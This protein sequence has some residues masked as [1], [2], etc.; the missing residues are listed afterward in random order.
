VAARLVAD[1][2]IEALSMR[3][4]AAECGVSSMTPY[5]YVGSKEEV[6][7]ALANRYLDE[8]DYPD[9]ESLSWED[10]LRQV[11]RSVRSV[12][13]SHPELVQIAARHRVNGLAGYRGAELVLGVL[14]RAGLDRSD[15]VSGFTALYAFTTGFVQREI[16]ADRTTHLAER[17]A[18]IAGL[19][20]EQF[21]NIRDCTDEFLYS[22]TEQHFDRGLD[23]I[24]RGIGASAI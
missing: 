22:N 23:F 21:S 13:L 17:L 24:I 19:P 7:R 5:R 10:Y 2:G 4:L 14:R 20:P 6:L 15:A 16:P 8:V 9:A 18:T 12:L 1:D 11:F 3:R